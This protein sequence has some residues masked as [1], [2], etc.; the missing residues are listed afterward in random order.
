MTDPERPAD[1]TR[2]DPGRWCEEHERYECTKGRKHGGTCHGLRIEGLPSCRMHAGVSGEVAKAKGAAVTAWSA[3]TG[4][5]AVAA[6]DAVLG[7]LHM[8]WLRVHL[9]AGLLEQQVTDA[10]ADAPETPYSEAGDAYGAGPIGH[11]AGLVGHTYSGVKDLGVFASGEAIRGLA[12]LE[13][14]ERDRCVRF[15]KA[16]HDMGIAERETAIAEAQ[17]E[18]FAGVFFRILDALGLSPE[19]L[20]TAAETMQRELLALGGGS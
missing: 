7:M 20:A 10:Q 13:A 11:G 9:Y 8:S 6:T 17:G 12:Q 4:Q 16:A 3:M 18:A 15:A 1:P 2:T 5:P 19:Q 14:Q